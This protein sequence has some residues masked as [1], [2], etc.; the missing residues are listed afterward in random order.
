MFKTHVFRIF[1]SNYYNPS[2]A[3]LALIS[4]AL[5]MEKKRGFGSSA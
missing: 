2:A 3:Q 4:V 5:A 1:N